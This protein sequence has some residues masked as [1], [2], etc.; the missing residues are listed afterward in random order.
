[1]G[2]IDPPPPYNYMSSYFHVFFLYLQNSNSLI[3]WTLDSAEHSAQ[4]VLEAASPAMILLKGPITSIDQIVCRSLDIVE[5]TVPSIN[6]PPE[7]VSF[8][9]F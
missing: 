8:I 7:M 9:L 3:H 1:M 5:Q 6:L 2:A 4:S